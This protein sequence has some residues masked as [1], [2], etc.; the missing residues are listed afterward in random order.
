MD[1]RISALLFV[2]AFLLSGCVYLTDHQGNEVTIQRNELGLAAVGQDVVKVASE[3]ELH[4]LVKGSIYETGELMSVFGAC[5]NSQDQPI[6]NASNDTITTATFSA[7]YPNGTQFIFDEE[8]PEI[9]PGYYLHQSNMSSVPGTYLTELTCSIEG[10]DQVAIAFGEWQNPYWVERIALLNES[11]ADVNANLTPIIDSLNAMNASLEGLSN[12]TLILLAN[13]QEVNMTT[14]EILT[15]AEEMNVS[16]NELTNML[17]AMNVSIEQNFQDI[18]GN[19]TTIYDA[20]VNLDFNGTNVSVDLSPVLDAINYM[21]QTI[22][23]SINNQTQNFSIQIGNFRQNVTDS[24]EITWDNIESV[25]TTI[26]DVN[27][28]VQDTLYWVGGVANN[29]V[30]RNNSYLAQLLHQLLNQTSSP[31]TNNTLTWVEN[32][33]NVVYYGNWNIDVEVY[34]SQG[35]VVG[36]P[37]VSCL[38]NTTNTPPTT[39]ELMDPI[40]PVANVNVDPYFSYTEQVQVLSGFNWTVWCEYN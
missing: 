33:S 37:V 34:N 2:F 1:Y 12:N 14:Q 36:W 38:I 39:N 28:S 30:D 32:T 15:Y 27:Q 24:F 21:N 6:L 16:M 5:L 18:D 35:R 11:I 17:S 29:T 3:D 4:A 23:N 13:M 26:L 19:L 22:L 40:T 8:L 31:V 10:S 25:N 20:I 7:Y 9:D